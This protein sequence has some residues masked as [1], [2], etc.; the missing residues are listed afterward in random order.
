MGA[1]QRSRGLWAC[2]SADSSRQLIG[3]A[4]IARHL[5]EGAE[6]QRKCPSF[7]LKIQPELLSTQYTTSMYHVSRALRAVNV[8]VC[9]SVCPRLCTSANY[10]WK[11]V[12][13]VMPTG[14]PRSISWM[15]LAPSVN[16]TSRPT[17]DL[18]S[19]FRLLTSCKIAGMSAASKPCDPRISISRPATRPIGTT[20]RSLPIGSPTYD[21]KRL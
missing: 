6:E 17:R 4:H 3:D 13:I 20:G 10:D 5:E 16:E 19:S 1:R 8:L 11:L 15:A 12:I 21:A 7:G 2:I 9:L 18:T 14:E